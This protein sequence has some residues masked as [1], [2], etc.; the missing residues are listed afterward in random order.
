MLKSLAQRDRTNWLI[1]VLLLLI[2]MGGA[3][4]RWH[5]LGERSVD[6]DEST[7]W[8]SISYPKFSDVMA[9]VNNNG[10]APLSFVVTYGLTRFFGDSEIPLRLSSFLAGC[11]TILAVYL[12]GRRGFGYMEGLIAAGMVA[13]MYQPLNYSQYSRMYAWMLLLATLAV[14]YWLDL[15]NSMKAG[16]R[17]PRRSAIL[18]GVLSLA[19]ILT[20][21]LVALMLVWQAAALLLVAWRQRMLKVTLGL[22]LAIS[23]AFLPWVPQLLTQIGRPSTHSWI[24]E[25]EPDALGRLL[26]WIVGTGGNWERPTVGLL[27]FAGLILLGLATAVLR[28]AGGF[29]EDK[30]P[31][32]LMQ[33]D[34]LLA[35]WAMVPPILLY[36]V[37]ITLKPL[38][39]ERY[40]LFTLPAFVLLAVR[41][42]TG[43]PLAEDIPAGVKK[44]FMGL[45]SCALIFFYLN[46]TVDRGR[47]Y[48]QNNGEFTRAVVQ[49]IQAYQRSTP[50]TLSATC[51]YRTQYDYYT[52]RL[53]R[54]SVVEI[55]FCKEDE[56]EAL[57]ERMAREGA[58][59]L[60]L[61][62]LHRRIS[63]EALNLLE[64]HYCEHD[65]TDFGS[66][67]VWLYYPREH[68]ACDQ[69]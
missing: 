33:P 10:Q 42:I 53:G 28:S 64:E 46:L 37:S 9:S 6:L 54:E 69:P 20:N 50:G 4:L 62:Q 16:K 55:G 43:L 2:L 15:F 65:L 7:T 58:E 39:L 32:N 23:L 57:Q 34:Y 49:T 63:D 29:D 67:K 13:V 24:R 47:Y 21:Y 14:Y 8:S 51:G 35:L 61:S 52:V 1:G 68:P 11:L 12:V 44:G 41:G 36:F 17:M 60:I 56:F 22:Y 38:Y 27:I 66:E 5:E 18:Y 59:A 31:G 48:E 3:W 25:P 30:Q 19:G 26:P 40:L 45:A